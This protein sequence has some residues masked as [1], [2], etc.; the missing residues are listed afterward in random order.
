M[1]SGCGPSARPP[2]DGGA[3]APIPS[4]TVVFVTHA[5]PTSLSEHRALYATAAGSND[6]KR[7]FNASFY[8]ADD[9]GVAQ[10]LLIEQG[11]RLNTDSWRVNPDGSMD[12]VYRLRNLTWH[13]GAPLSADDMVL[14]WQMA[15]QPDYAVSDL[16]ALDLM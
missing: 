5:E 2:R 9:R 4:P 14:S 3:G 10:P 6:A 15:K 12:P 7:L 8:L 11:P 16:K 1:A 13:D